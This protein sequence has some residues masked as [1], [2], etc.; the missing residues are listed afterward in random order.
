MDKKI[1][2]VLGSGFS[3]PLGAPTLV[4]LLNPASKVIVEKLFPEND[5]PKLYKGGNFS[6]SYS[7]FANGHSPRNKSLPKMWADAE[8]YLD[9]LDTATVVTDG[10]A[11]ARLTSVHMGLHNEIKINGLAD[12]TRRIVAAECSVFLQRTSPDLEIWQPYLR[13]ANKLNQNHTIITFNYDTVL[14]TLVNKCNGI[15]GHSFFGLPTYDS[16]Y[17]IISGVSVVVKLHGSVDWRVNKP[18]I[19]RGEPLEALKCDSDQLVIA[20][21]G[22]TKRNMVSDIL[23][24]LWNEA[25][26]KLCEADVV[27]F[28]GYRFPPSDAEARGR[29]LGALMK[30]TSPNL[31]LYTV[32]GPNDDPDNRRLEALLK[33]ATAQRENG[34]GKVVRIPLWS[35]DFMSVYQPE[36]FE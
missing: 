1:V 14:E 2:W 5:F 10:P 26:I 12:I 15:G 27:V 30:N 11:T 17:V 35:Q 33:Y 7:L 20:T 32:L 25:E 36:M 34:P 23:S 13:W 21:P 9:Y 24:P 28:M 6:T 4:E 8:Q 29:L 3:V 22:P 16:D 31:Q 19:L 18:Q